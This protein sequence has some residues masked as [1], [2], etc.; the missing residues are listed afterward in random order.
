LNKI[1]GLLGTP[2]TKEA[3]IYLNKAIGE[4]V[5]KNDI[6]CTFY[7]DSEERLILAKHALQKLELYEIL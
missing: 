1:C 3:G 6:L 2:A 7:T 4:K 5:K